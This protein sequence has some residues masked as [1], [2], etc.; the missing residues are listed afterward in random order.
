[1]SESYPKIIVTFNGD[2]WTA[3]CGGVEV[4]AFDPHTVIDE[5]LW[6][7]DELWAI[8]NETE[9]EDKDNVKRITVVKEE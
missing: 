4:S 7:V 9:Q 5:I 8:E 6:Q 3:Q 1:M 2:R